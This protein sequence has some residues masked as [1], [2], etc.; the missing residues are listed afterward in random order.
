MVLSTKSLVNTSKTN[1]KTLNWAFFMSIRL[2]YQ[3]QYNGLKRAKNNYFKA[4]TQR[5]PPT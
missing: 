4:M 2:S 3:K 5:Q 1:R